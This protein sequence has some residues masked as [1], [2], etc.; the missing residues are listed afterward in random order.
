MILMRWAG[1]VIQWLSQ[2]EMQ[3]GNPE[4][5]PKAA[6]LRIVACKRHVK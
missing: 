3:W 1:Y 4:R 2:R 6:V 5:P